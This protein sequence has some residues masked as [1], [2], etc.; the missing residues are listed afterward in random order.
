MWRSIK[1]VALK[2]LS[3][4][5]AIGTTSEERASRPVKK[6]QSRWDAF[7]DGVNRLPRTILIFLCIGFFIWPVIWANG[8]FL[9]WARAIREVPDQMWYLVGIIVGVIWGI[10]KLSEDFPNLSGQ[11]HQPPADPAPQKDPA[12]VNPD[13]LP[14]PP[15]PPEPPPGGAG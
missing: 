9:I 7:M 12:P 2:A 14:P 3:L 4:V 6:R 5:T 15:P 10:K 13:A 11:G 1:R 8:D